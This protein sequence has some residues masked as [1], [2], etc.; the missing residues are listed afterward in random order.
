MKRGQRRG[1][2]P[3]EEVEW[4][5][6]HM[7]CRSVR[8]LFAQY[9]VVF[10]T[11][12]AD[13]VSFRRVLMRH[14]LFPITDMDGYDNLNRMLRLYYKH[15]GNVHWEFHSPPQIRTIREPHWLWRWHDNSLRT[16]SGI[17]FKP[18]PFRLK[19]KQFEQDVEN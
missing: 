18:Y 14:N 16:P 3:Q 5:K 17:T 10:N 12:Y 8:S 1:D 6:A 15:K 11:P 9:S 13:I 7:R 2:L 19:E 4:L